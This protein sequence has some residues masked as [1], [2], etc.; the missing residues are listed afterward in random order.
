MTIRQV[1]I[2]VRWKKSKVGLSEK[3]KKAKP[4]K[5]GRRRA[6]DA[7]EKMPQNIRVLMAV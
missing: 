6:V 1:R 5:M 7:N 2:K 4:V 3:E